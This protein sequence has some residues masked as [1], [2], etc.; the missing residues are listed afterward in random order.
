ML[1]VNE[2]LTA[3]KGYSTSNFNTRRLDNKS[4]IKKISNYKKI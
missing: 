1:G 4:S 2:A 3:G